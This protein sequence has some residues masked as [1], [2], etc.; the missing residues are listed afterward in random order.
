MTKNRHALVLTGGPA[1]GKTELFEQL[2]SDPNFAHFVFLEELARK[3]LL[4]YPAYR[5]EWHQFHL[6][7][8][9]AQ[10]EREAALGE[11][12]FIT[13]R[14]T[15]DTFAFHP[16]TA[17]A[18]NSSAAAE[19]SRYTRVIQLG[20]SASLGEKFYRTDAVRNESID[21]ALS[22]EAALRKVWQDHPGYYF[23]EA[24]TDAEKKRRKVMDLFEQLLD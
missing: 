23:I 19:Y 8:Y 10:V 13:D 16:E 4:Q 5:T 11:S 24:E 3:L 6:D 22:I 1:S 15:A 9:Q 14:G 18:V 7:I 2:Q 17:K 12:N 20:S 21:E